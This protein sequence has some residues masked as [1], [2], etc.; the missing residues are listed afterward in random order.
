MESETPTV[1]AVILDYTWFAIKCYFLAI[2]L[3]SLLVPSVFQTT[4]W[5]KA[6]WIILKQAKPLPILGLITL[7]LYA[8]F[9]RTLMFVENFLFP[10]L[11][12]VEKE[13][14]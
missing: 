9:T 11:R 4:N 2:L 1:V 6:S 10:G 7:S 14:L 5:R 3:I 8:V 12:Q 13:F